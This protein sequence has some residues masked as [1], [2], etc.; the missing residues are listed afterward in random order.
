MDVV[1]TCIRRDLR[2]YRSTCE[3][4]RRHL[5]DAR[6]HV[7]TKAPDFAAFRKRCG[8]DLVL[9]DE[10]EVLDDLSLDDLRQFP[11]PSF[12]QGAGWY[13]QQFLKF[14]FHRLSDAGDHF[15]VWDADTVLLRPLEFVDDLG[16]S[17]FVKGAEHH[18]PYFET[19]EALFG[20]PA[21]REYSFIS[22]HQV[23]EK[24]VLRRMLADIE[25][26][27]EMGRSWPRVVMDRLRG[28]DSNEFSEYETYGHY[29]KRHH[30]D[31]LVARD[32]PWTRHGETEAG[33][34]PR[35]EGLDRL[36]ADFAFAAFE[37]EAA[38][39]RVALRRVPRLRRALRR[40]RSRLRGISPR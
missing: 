14:G 13:F 10:R 34:P 21:D 2:V 23:V 8:S 18:Q 35:R 7:I 1:S 12:P 24:R 9:I 16:R 31:R 32:L 20:Y 3:S 11:M 40:L 22:Q 5:P 17:I 25:A 19:F 30:P 38:P 27:D 6:I 36:A 33:Y 4:L 15:L 26:R 37:S 39:L 28:T 29:F